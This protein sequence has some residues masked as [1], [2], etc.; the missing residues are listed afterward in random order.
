MYG[1]NNSGKLFVDELTDWLLETCFI[2]YQCQMYL[3][4]NYTPD[5]NCFVV[6][7]YVDE[8]VYWY[9]SEALGK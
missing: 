7:S 9:T 2:Q 4:Y 3:Y 8:Y 5:G 6:L 1:I